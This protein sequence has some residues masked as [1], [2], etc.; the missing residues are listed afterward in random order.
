MASSLSK[1]R[2][3]PATVKH[4]SPVSCFGECCCT[5]KWH[6]WLQPSQLVHSTCITCSTASTNMITH[7]TSWC[8][9][10]CTALTGA[11]RTASSRGINYRMIG[12]Y[13]WPAASTR[14]CAGARVCSCFKRT[15]TLMKQVECHRLFHLGALSQST[16][17]CWPQIT[18]T[19]APRCTSLP[20]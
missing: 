4:A 7:G 2:L 3:T 13:P 19:F 18:I 15:P 10:V 6:E 11:F 9:I 14:H 16:T 20:S 8:L 5:V 12:K 1:P 17:R